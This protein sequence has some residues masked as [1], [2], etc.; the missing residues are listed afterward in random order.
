MLSRVRARVEGGSI[1][2]KIFLRGGEFGQLV[3][4]RFNDG[5]VGQYEQ[6]TDPN[7]PLTLKKVS[8]E[9]PGV[10]YLQARGG[11]KEG[12]LT[13]QEFILRL[14]GAAHCLRQR[15]RK[16]E[17]GEIRNSPPNLDL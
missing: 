12:R 3:S 4:V 7:R 5:T 1:R 14:K 11:R 17:K 2:G 10:V 8:G 16:K 13:R 6:F 9:G 15:K